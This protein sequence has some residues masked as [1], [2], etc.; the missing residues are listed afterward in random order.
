MTAA[1]RS[2]ALIGLGLIGSSIARAAREHA[3]EIELTGYDD[4][5]DI[6]RRAADLQF[7]DRVVE[8]PA[9]A[10]TGADLVI[11]CVPVGS[12][13]A[14]ARAIA[15]G[16]KQGAIISDVGSSKAIVATV[17]REVL[18]DAII[19]PGH[20]IAGTENSGPEAGFATLFRGRWCILTPDESAPSEAVQRLSGFWSSLGARVEIMDARQHDLTLAATSHLPHLIAYTIVGTASDL[21]SVTQNEVIKYSAGGF[22]D[23]TRIAASDPKVWRDI[24]LAN[25]NELLEQSRLFQRSLAGL[26]KLIESGDGEGLESLIHQASSTRAHWRMG[27]K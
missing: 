10:V 1:I 16:L 24:L 23:F 7:V 26:E 14:A 5:P 19:I 2:I 18:P 17:L 12:M 13:S 8:Q 27:K 22:R 3:A 15:P 4:D 21:E 20:P 11:L 6:R 9:A 25:K